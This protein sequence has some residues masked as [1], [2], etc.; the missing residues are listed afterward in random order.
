MATFFG[1]TDITVNSDDFGYVFKVK[2]DEVNQV[3]YDVSEVSD[4]TAT[5]SDSLPLSDAANNN[6]EVYS[7][8]AVAINGELASYLDAYIASNAPGGSWEATYTGLS[9]AQ[10]DFYSSAPRPNNVGPNPYAGV[11][12]PIILVNFKDSSGNVVQGLSE[13]FVLSN[14]ST[15]PIDAALLV[16][17]DAYV[18]G[19]DYPT[20]N[21]S[22]A[23]TLSGTYYYSC[24]EKNT[25]IATPAGD[26]LVSELKIGDKV[27]TQDGRAVDSK[28]IG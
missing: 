10:A 27:L 12:Q 24:F 23:S 14:T 18:A 11:D 28:W 5:M 3:V 20:V 13:Y 26:V 6:N 9:T 2:I 21:L 1:S 15:P 19:A 25:L 17:P 8:E 4:V 22:S 16:A 7:S